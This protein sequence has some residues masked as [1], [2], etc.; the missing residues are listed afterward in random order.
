ME[1]LLWKEI[2]EQPEIIR[3]LI[4]EERAHVIRLG[5]E[6]REKPCRFIF[7]AAR[8]TSDNAARYGQYLFGGINRL[9]VALTAPSLFTAYRTPPRLEEALVIGISQSGQSPDIVEVL[10]EARRQGAP[11][12]AVTNDGNSPLALAAEHMLTLSAGREQSVA[13]TK[14]YTSTLAVLA[15]LSL[16]MEDLLREDTL[17]PVVP[18]MEAALE[19]EPQ[20]QAAAERIADS[21]RAVVLG[22]GYH[23]CTAHEISLKIKELSGV[24]AEP[25]SSADFQHGP[26]AMAEGGLP[27]II[28]SM[29]A[30]FR[31]EMTELAGLVRAQGARVLTIADELPGIQPADSWIPLPRGEPEWLTPIAAVIPG[32]L[33]AFHLTRARGLDPDRPRHIRKVTLTH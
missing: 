5:R 9:P 17:A 20:A 1:S 15:M 6:L 26:I 4:A 22:R 29:G 24:E 19:A 13:A 7:L 28:V 11:T 18:W 27:V 25:Y 16:A 3:R 30:T 32:Q 23:Y 8:G 14:T 10:E 33:L 2:H 12:V 21:T 31:R